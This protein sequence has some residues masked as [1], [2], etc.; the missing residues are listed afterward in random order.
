M[1][2]FS[3]FI[4]VVYFSFN[5]WF[6][7]LLTKISMKEAYKLE[8]RFGNTFIY[9]FLRPFAFWITA[10]LFILSIIGKTSVCQV[11]LDACKSNYASFSIIFATVVLISSFIT[12]YIMKV[13]ILGK[14]I[15]P[16]F[17]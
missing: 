6:F 8:Y 2:F 5:G 17:S 1:V 13:I 4:M 16:P 10:N 12:Y 11:I 15:W 7:I 14:E 3:F 9:G